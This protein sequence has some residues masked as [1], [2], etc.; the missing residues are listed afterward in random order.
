M[1]TLYFYVW[2][3]VLTA[4]QC[5]ETQHLTS[6]VWQQSSAHVLR[7][8]LECTVGPS[9]TA[10]ASLCIRARCRDSRGN[11]LAEFIVGDSF[12][13]KVCGDDERWL[14]RFDFDVTL[15]G[16]GQPSLWKYQCRSVRRTIRTWFSVAIWPWKHAYVIEARELVPKRPNSCLGFVIR[17]IISSFVR[18]F[19]RQEAPHL[20][21]L[22]I[23]EAKQLNECNRNTIS[24]FQY[25]HR[26]MTNHRQL[27]RNDKS[28]VSPN[29]QITSA[30][31]K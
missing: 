17:I 3:A 2:F 28:S 13:Y 29:Y 31:T 22:E 21:P 30:D 8:G 20:S 18:M 4:K 16:G 25:R 7:F 11:F 5:L 15:C 23:V 26:S 12:G 1:H 10:R 9:Q 27:V 19:T 6:T 24:R 14:I